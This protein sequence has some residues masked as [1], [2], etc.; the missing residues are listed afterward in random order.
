MLKNVTY[1]ILSL[2][3]SQDEFSRSLLPLVTSALFKGKKKSG[4]LLT[5]RKREGS[6]TLADEFIAIVSDNNII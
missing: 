6:W 5:M 4:F 1:I 3:I 2:N